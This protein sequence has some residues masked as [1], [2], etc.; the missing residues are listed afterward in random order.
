[1]DKAYDKQNSNNGVWTSSPEELDGFPVDLVAYEDACRSIPF[2]P[3]EKRK[4]ES[5]GKILSPTE[6]EELV[7]ALLQ[8]AGGPILMSD[9][10]QEARKHVLLLSLA[11][12]DRPVRADEE[13][14]ATL[15]DLLRDESEAQHL[16]W[17]DLEI[18]E[19]ESIPRS[20]RI[21]TA[22]AQ[23]SLVRIFCGYYLPKKVYNE[24]VTLEDWG[25]TSTVGDQVKKIDS[26][27]RDEMYWF[28][29]CRSNLV[30]MDNE[31]RFKVELFAYILGRLAE[32]CT[33]SPEH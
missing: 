24:A 33:S 20:E 31:Y 32:K 2:Y 27:L 10:F 29:D 14:A 26:I 13:D 25:K 28:E 1:M 7:L 6:A 8:A 12:L 18:M 5:E 3:R 11:D 9:L 23:A 19:R 16:T 21:W 15:G 22:V 17:I 30:G 4:T